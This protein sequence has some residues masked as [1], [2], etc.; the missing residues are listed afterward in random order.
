MDTWTPTTTETFIR[1][2]HLWSLWNNKNLLHSVFGNC[3]SRA[4]TQP[5]QR[6]EPVHTA[7][8]SLRCTQTFSVHPDQHT[9][10]EQ[11]KHGDVFKE[12]HWIKTRS[13]N[14]NFLGERTSEYD[15]TSHIQHTAFKSRRHSC[16]YVH[17]WTVVYLKIIECAENFIYPYCLEFL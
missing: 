8:L 14:L 16:S 13:R 3:L 6:V 15:A 10:P 9:A 7:L 17:L 5:K 11:R 12:R 1:K 4:W 2:M